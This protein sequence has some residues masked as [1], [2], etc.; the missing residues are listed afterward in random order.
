[1][2]GSVWNQ[3]AAGQSTVQQG[4]QGGCGILVEEPADG[5]RLSDPHGLLPAPGPHLPR[6]VLGPRLPQVS[7]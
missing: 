5:E 7:L 2:S 6:S 1:M 4:C 3:S